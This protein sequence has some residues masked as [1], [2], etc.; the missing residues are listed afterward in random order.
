[1]ICFIAT[2]ISAAEAAAHWIELMFVK[3]TES[4]VSAAWVSDWAG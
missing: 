2:G 3:R 4:G 1:V